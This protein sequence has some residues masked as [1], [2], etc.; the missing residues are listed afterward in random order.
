MIKT[1]RVLSHFLSYPGRDLQ[2]F[3]YEGTGELQKEKILDDRILEGIREFAAFYSDMDLIDWQASYVSLFDTS[4]NTSLYIFEHL[5]GDSK[6][7]GQ[8]MNDLLEFYRDNGLVLTQGELP[9]YL[10]VF[11]EFI[12]DIEMP[13]AAELL[14]QPVNVINRI[15]LVLK[16]NNNPYRHVFEAII[17]LSSEK[18]GDEVPE[19]G[20]GNILNEGCDEL[21]NEPPA[22]GCETLNPENQTNKPW[23]II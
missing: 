20:A 23:E 7:R 10:P 14:S 8:A 1:F 5:K 21:Y 11:L 2:T 12:S 18:P 16:K 6:E 22:F 17:S 3:L 19:A 15:C 9:D 13:K 4:R